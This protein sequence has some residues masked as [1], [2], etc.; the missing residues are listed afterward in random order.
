M[1]PDEALLRRP[2]ALD[3]GDLPG[4]DDEEVAVSVA[5]A[6]EDLLRLHGAALARFGQRRELSIVQARI[7]PLKIGCLLDVPGGPGDH[8]WDGLLVMRP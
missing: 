5:L 4:Q 6:E 8:A 2:A 7:G 1:D 3:H